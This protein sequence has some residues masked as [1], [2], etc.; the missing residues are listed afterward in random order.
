MV[1]DAGDDLRMRGLDQEGS[2]TA[3]ED[4]GIAYDQPGNRIWAK[5][6]R[7]ASV[8]PRP[9]QRV[10]GVREEIVGSVD[11]SLAHR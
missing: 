4:G 3:D 6:A 9:I 10:R 7:V 1:K 11:Y 2:D 5:E 8:E